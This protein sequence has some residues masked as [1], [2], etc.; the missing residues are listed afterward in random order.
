MET[1]I[2]EAQIFPITPPVARADLQGN[3]AHPELRGEALFSPLGRGTLVV[4]RAMGLPAGG[5]LGLH[6]HE[7]GD[8]SPTWEDAFTNAGGH[9]NPDESGHP[10]HAGD[11]PP[12]LSSADGVA[13]L[14]VYTDRFR[15]DQIIGRAILIHGMADDFRSQPAGDSGIRI[16]CGP[17]RSI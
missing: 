2:T 7:T 10:F 3:A 15:P 8:C 12:L 14:A 1:K 17:I 4:V 6:I 13:L 5:F 11:L 16:G 9:W